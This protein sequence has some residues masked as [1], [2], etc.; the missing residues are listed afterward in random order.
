MLDAEEFRR[1]LD[2]IQ[3]PV[4]IVRRSGKIDLA[5]ASARATL[6]KSL[7][8]RHLSEFT[9]TAPEV[10]DS[11][12]ARCAA[13]GSPVIASIV[14][15]SGAGEEHRFQ[16]KG[17]LLSKQQGHQSDRIVLRC[18]AQAFREFTRVSRQVEALNRDNRKQR[19]ARAVLQESLNQRDL[20]LR[21]VQHRVRNQTQMLLSMVSA[22]RRKSGSDELS[23]FLE[24]L[25]QR[26]TAMGTVQ[27]L[28]YTSARLESLSA[29][30]LITDLCNSIVQTWPA[31][32]DLQVD[33]VDADLA[34]DVAVPLAL[35]VSELLTNALKH[36][37]KYGPGLA[38]VSLSEDHDDLVLQVRDS[39]PGMPACTNVVPASSGLAMVRGMCRQIGGSFDCADDSGMCCIVRFPRPVSRRP[40][41][42]SETDHAFGL[43]PTSASAGVHP[44][45]GDPAS[46]V[47]QPR[48]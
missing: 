20:L 2:F 14:L 30:R 39:G 26:L 47:R 6:G 11:Y 34:N 12:L 19:H 33:C 16:V 5:N 37:L 44:H 17:A 36:G 1:L 9:T 10:L 8:E 29:Q 42:Q 21:E 15:R 4:F 24:Q 22:A 41:E 25:R 45:A 35:I 28:M 7:S 31:G 38:K 46:Q 13:S 23:A 40:D 18:N 48:D 27:Q 32:A 43:S 3:D